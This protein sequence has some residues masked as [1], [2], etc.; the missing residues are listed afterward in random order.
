MFLNKMEAKI[1]ES[2][3]RIKIGQIE[4]DFEGS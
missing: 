1:M 4:I 3:I 2:K